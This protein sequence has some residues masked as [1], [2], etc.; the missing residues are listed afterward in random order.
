MRLK[1]F[2]TLALGLSVSGA[3]LADDYQWSS[4]YIGGGGFVSAV[5]PSMVDEN[6]FYVRTDVG[7]AYRWD[8][9][10]YRWVS[11]M[12]WV[13]VNERGLL[14]VEALAVDPSTSGKVYM[15]AGTS[16]WNSGRSAFLRS[17]DKG[18]TWETIYVWD[19]TGYYGSAVT[20]FS[21]H[22]NGMGRSNGEALAIDPN[23]SDNMFYG[24]RNKGLFKSTDNGSSWTHVDAFTEASGSDT[25]WNGSG[26][27]FVMYSPGSSKVLYAGFLREGTTSSGTF[28]NVFT[29]SDGGSSWEALPIP[30]SLRTTA[31][32]GVVRLMP[33]RAVATSDGKYL[34]VTFADGAG[35]HSMGWDEGWGDIWDGF[36]RGAVLKYDVSNKAWTD[37]SPED[38]ID[39]G[40]TGTSDY[41]MTDYSDYD[42]YQYLPPYGGIAINPDDDDEILVT[43]LGYQ[44][45]QFW[46]DSDADSWDD[47]WGSNIFRTTDG[48]EEWAPSFVYYWTDGGYYPS[49]QQMD[50]N[51]IGW[52]HGGSIHWSG[53]VAY[54]P[55]NTEQVFVTS[56]NG[57]FR[58]DNLSDY[59]YE[60]A[61][62]W[63]TDKTLTTNQV[64]HFSAHGI[65]EVV[66][67][68]VVSIPG[69][70]MV[71]V[72]ADYDGF[73]HDSINVY[74]SQRHKTS[75]GGSYVSLGSTRSLAF[76]P[77]SGTL[78]KVTDARV[79]EDTYNDIP[80]DPLQFSSDSGTTWTV[81]TYGSLDTSYY[82]GSVAISADGSVS[83]WTPGSGTT[84]V[85][86]Y[87]NSSYTAISGIDGAY[88]VGDPEN[89]EVFYAYVKGDGTFF[90]SEDQGETFSQVGTPGTSAFEK[91]R[92][93]PEREGD[94]WLPIA[95]Q[96]D[97]GNPSS[98]SLLRSTD[99]GTTWSS[100]GSVGYCEAVGFGKAATDSGYPA[101]YVYAVIDGTAG[102]Y[103][104]DDEGET[105][106]RVN[107]DDHEFGGLANGEFVVGDMNTYGI[108]YVS[109]AGRGIA[110]RA[111]SSYDMTQSGSSSPIA[112]QKLEVSVGASLR[113]SVLSLA[114][115]N[116]TATVK[117]YSMTGK[118]VCTK[119][120]SSGTSVDLNTLV[121]SAGSYIVRVTN[122]SKLLLN[123]KVGLT[124]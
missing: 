60:L 121:G 123:G 99:G 15:V 30:D 122:G 92:L 22:G 66:P 9:S 108:V 58:T 85:Y 32:G 12:D 56:G 24:S 36:G 95:V 4:V 51:G 78:V 105:W 40:E 21:A 117:I 7:G 103:G 39:A 31:G 1:T 23:D 37:V 53:S 47:Q 77:K 59:T 50:E 5:I 80:I 14:G 33:Q 25:T 16:Y 68:D 35:P 65:E 29:S 42:N 54:N 79:Y 115:Q 20:L 82:A 88:V 26:F 87:S 34:Y 55:S 94:V 90:K 71:S 18:S 76:A 6:L 93:A 48:G 2:A 62:S 74:P 13:D 83:I 98:G 72:I 112:A 111:P 109:T 52:M 114:I 84:T 70:P 73:R 118:K 75:V 116:G 41:D 45:P 57:V 106:T 44:G 119:Q 101:V 19:S 28:E 104:S 120:Y 43:T 102:I 69:G 67:E 107:D 17:S 64:W 100:V 113:G 11:L 8:N 63:D 89:E 81:A 27:S 46:Y 38:Y 49:T 97:D 61:N 3:A 110:V 10:D 124:K 96:D 86:R 91:F